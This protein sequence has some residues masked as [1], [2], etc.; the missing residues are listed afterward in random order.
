[1]KLGW[2]GALGIVL[3]V[4]LLAWTLWPTKV[5]YHAVWAV[6]RGANLPLLVLAALTATLTF[7][8]R[9]RRWQTILSPVAHVPFGALWRSTAIGMMINNVVPARVGELARAFS[10]TREDPRVPLSAAVAS[11][12]VD[13]VF[14]VIVLFGLMFG[15][16]LD[17]A[18]PGATRI[19]G[20][21]VAVWA[22][23]AM[24]MIGVLLVLLYGIAL[25]PERLDA[26]FSRVARPLSP[27][28][29]RRGSAA[30]H[31]FAR[32]LS[33]LH[34]PRRF[35]SVLGWTLAHW[36]TNALAFWLGFRAVGID[37][38]ASAAFFLQG[39][40]AIGVAVPSSPGFFGV[41][42]AAARL[43]LDVYDVPASRSVSW[44]IGYHIL[45]FI[46]ITLIGAWYASRLGFSLAQ[47]ERATPEPETPD[48]DAPAPREPGLRSV[49]A[50]GAR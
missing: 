46:P 22:R 49:A 34:S 18:F 16:M 1:M 10:L 24:L 33:V 28:L 17:P 15:A 6:L 36:L 13:R 44:A 27:G 25:M 47:L 35:V 2:R 14:D 42:E 39:V 37:A 3:S 23:G 31:A 7:P 5:D 41:F 50:D 12:G 29:Q 4:A 43:G 38:P 26:L 9:A 30:L 32:G 8:L 48:A 19:A 45:S 11:I 20:Q 21:P 40:I